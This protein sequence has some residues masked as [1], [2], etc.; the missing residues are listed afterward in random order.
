[1]KILITSSVFPPEAAG[2]ATYAYEFSKRATA[3]GHK[4]TV[5]TLADSE[6]ERPNG[7]DIRKIKRS[8][9]KLLRQLSLFI[10][11]LKAAR[12][13]DIIYAQNP[14]AIGLPSVLAGR[15]CGRP[16]IVKY[17]GDTAWEKAFREGKTKKF[18]ED[19]LKNPDAN[20]NI[21]RVERFVF[22][23]ADRIITPSNFL[24]RMLTKYHNV[25]KEKIV[26][27]PNAVD[28]AAL[29]AIHPTKQNAII[30]VARLVPWKGIKELIRVM[31]QIWEKTGAELW[32]VGD[33]PYRSELEALAGELCPH[34]IHFFGNLSHEDTIQKIASA[35]VL[36]LNSLYEGMSHVLLEAMA[37]QTPI[38]ATNVCGNPELVENKKT[39]FL[40]E[41][42]N[43]EELR[44]TIIRAVEGNSNKLIKAA[45]TKV[46]AHS[47]DTVM[48]R[49]LDVLSHASLRVK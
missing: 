35:R 45:K 38:V 39:G 16:V 22:R 3:L 5:I 43:Q 40:I 42:L 31:P 6:V 25:P 4:I 28:L 48:E 15:L 47:W 23:H 18:L 20:R 2:P 10:N 21:L 11:I 1:M 9:N 14:A 7:I 27:I 33:G 13:C 8:R 46:R 32:I 29:K 19:F 34:T 12:H 26:I 36:V 24:S 49:T 30:T 17:V 37:L 41:P 44:N